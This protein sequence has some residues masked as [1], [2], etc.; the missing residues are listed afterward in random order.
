MF[1]NYRTAD[2][3]SCA[4]RIERGLCSV[5]GSVNVFL[6][7]RSGFDERLLH[8]VWRTDALIAVI[9]PRWLDVADARGDRPLTDPEDWTRREILAALDGGI[10]VIPLL[11]G[12]ADRPDARVLPAELARLARCPCRRLDQRNDLGQLVERLARIPVATRR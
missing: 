4:L 2:E 6:A 11:I 9:G 12:G 10:T 3:E 1:V 7:S 8:E 5:F